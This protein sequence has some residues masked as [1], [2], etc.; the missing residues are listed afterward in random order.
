MIASGIASGHVLAADWLFLVAA[1]LF[2]LAAI[3]NIAGG[4]VAARFNP[5]NLAFIGLALVAFGWLVL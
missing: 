5:L 2:V 1:I 3:I 4:T